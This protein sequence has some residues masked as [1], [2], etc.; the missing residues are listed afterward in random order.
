[1]GTRPAAAPRS[2]TDELRSRPDAALAALLRDRPDLGVPLPSDLSALGVRAASRLSVQ[3][4]LDG[5]DTPAL[6]VLEVLAA[7][8]EPTTP[9][10]VSALWGALPAARCSTGCAHSGSSG[11]RRVLQ[12][13][14]AA[15]DILGPHPAGLGPSSPTRPAVAAAARGAA[16][17]PRAPADRRPETALA[18]LAEHLGRA[19]SSRLLA[20]RRTA[21]AVLDRLTWGPPVGQVP[22]ADRRS[23][24]R[25]GRSSGCSPADCSASRTP[26]TSCCPARSRSC[27]AAAAST[28][29][30]PSRR[31]WRRSASPRLVE[32]PRGAAAEAVRL[33][34]RSATWGQVPPPVLRAGGLGVREL[35][36]TA[37][38]LEVDEA[39]GGASSRSRSPPGWS[40]TT[41]RS[42]RA[43]RRRRPSTVGRTRP[44]DRWPPWP[45]P[46]WRRR[47]PPG[48]WGASDERGP[49]RRASAATSTG[50]RGPEVRLAVLRPAGRGPARAPGS[51]RPRRCSRCSLAAPRRAGAHARPAGRLGAG[52]GRLARR[53]RARR[54]ARPAGRAALDSREA[55][56]SRRPRR[57][58][59]ARAGRPG[60]PAGR[61]HGGG[62]RAAEPELDRRARLVADVESRGGATVFR[63]TPR[64]RAPRPGR[65]PDRRRPARASWLPR[66]RT[67]VPQPLAYL[68]QDTARRYGRI[69]IGAAQCYVRSDDEGALA[70]LLADRRTAAL[71]LRRLAPTVL[72]AQA[73][74]DGAVGA[75]RGRGWRR[76][77]SRPDG[78]SL[79]RPPARPGDAAARRPAPDPRARP[80]APPTRCSGRGPA[81]RGRAAGRGRGPASRTAGRPAAG[82]DGPGVHARHAAGRRGR[83]A[84]RV[85]I[86]YADAGGR[87]SRAGSS[88]RSRSRPAG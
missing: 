87:R 37:A 45:A 5:L 72:A 36:R 27:C 38:A 54:A 82:P 12:L 21:S 43:G 83:A 4:A 71:R 68:V 61:P 64:N 33:A 19:D 76:P 41:A 67:P 65:R 18:R 66:R 29:A 84:S 57:R 81:R 8:P 44:G 86:G 24:G 74:R 40:R 10:Q 60:A 34:G 39:D 13:V 56:D 25:R 49:A 2:L 51:R 31:R 85:W 62:A 42:A 11:A 58:A 30:Q 48:S 7:L 26:A 70:E 63:F 46:G 22:D 32:P 88:S 59:A 75:A 1:M 73:A 3:R 78:G 14:R 79:L 35:R 50:R 69:R 15:R 9:A 23:A 6:Q 52:R 47:A 77:R 55:A 17:G 20:T 80:P 16:R 28:A 53:H